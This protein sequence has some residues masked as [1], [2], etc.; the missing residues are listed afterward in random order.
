M[1]GMQT[2]MRTEDFSDSPSGYLVDAQLTDRSPSG[3]V[4][5]VRYQALMPH[6]LP[7]EMAATDRLISALADASHALGELSGLGHNL[8]NPHLLIQ[9]FI[10]KEA[11][12]SSKIEGT[13]TNIKELYAYEA[14]QRARG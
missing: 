2:L 10:R 3:D 13:Q 5:R 7:P 1:V 9:P 14:A 12:L 4:Q 8:P 11:V 6:P